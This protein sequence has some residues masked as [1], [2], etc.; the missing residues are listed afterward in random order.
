M[1]ARSIGSTSLSIGLVT[2]PVKLYSAVKEH[3]TSFS[4]LH[5]ECGT[6]VKQQLMCPMHDKP[7]EHSETVKGFE[8]A[9]GQYV[10]F[11]KTDFAALEASQPSAIEVE[12][13]VPVSVL[14]ALTV[15][16]SNYL[17]PDKGGSKAYQLV[18]HAMQEASVVGVARASAKGRTYLA[19]VRP[20]G[21]VLALHQLYFDTEVLSYSDIDVPAGA[22][23]VPGERQL[24]REL[25]SRMRQDSFDSSAYR[26]EYSDRVR[27]AADVKAAGGQI[28]HQPDQPIAHVVDLVEAL[29]RSIAAAPPKPKGTV[30]KAASEKPRRRRAS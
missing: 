15:S 24:A 14:D 2:V 13:F 8:V 18:L 9:P 7:I 6:K 12:A 30:R 5:A 21:S 26:D 19:I 3:E 22:A 10:V 1:A 25:V 23:I 28:A 17:G 27:A 11:T 16:K 29:K 20:Y 4:M